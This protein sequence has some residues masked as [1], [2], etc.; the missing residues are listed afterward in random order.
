[1]WGR[2]ELCTANYTARGS[3]K[4][5]HYFWVVSPL[6]SPRIMELKRIHSPEAPKHQA[7][8]SLCPWCGK[9]GQNEGTVVNHLHTGH[10]C[11]GLICERCLSY[12]TT[13][14]DTMC[15]HAQG[16]ESMHLCKGKLDEEV[17][18]SP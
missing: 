6:E 1:M 18:K 17:E 9:E 10:Y 12:F 5:L 3:T 14:S 11:L 2:K 15:H 13:I 16:C 4:D 7:S 8:L